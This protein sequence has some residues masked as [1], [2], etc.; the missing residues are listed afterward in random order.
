[1]QD[2]RTLGTGE[3][4]PGLAFLD[5]GVDH[6][7]EGLLV[8]DGGGLDGGVAEG[9][10]VD[11]LQDG[12]APVAVGG[13]DGSVSAVFS[14]ESCGIGSAGRLRF[15]WRLGGGTSSSSLAREAKRCFS[16]SKSD[17]F[18]LSSKTADMK[19]L[20]GALF[21]A[22]DQVGDRDVELGRVDH[23][24]VEQQRADVLLDGFGLALGHAEQH[25]EFDAW[26][27]AAL[28]GQEPGEG[29]VEQVVAG[30]ADPDVGIR[31]GCS[32]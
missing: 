9:R 15:C 24:G 2:R 19:V 22:A 21:E 12:A 17:S 18:S 23:R 25:L 13:R 11:P 20:A 16:R 4:A 14:K 27:H 26:T 32:E 10:D 28:L 1:M 7:V 30:D 5:G 3:G 29:D 31:S 6:R 8:V